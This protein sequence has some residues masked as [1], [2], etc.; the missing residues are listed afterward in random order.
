[1]IMMLVLFAFRT[2]LRSVIKPE[3]KCRTSKKKVSNESHVKSYE[4]SSFE[5]GLNGPTLP[6][7]GSDLRTLVWYSVLGDVVK[8]WLVSNCAVSRAV[9]NFGRGT[10]WAALKKQSTMVRMVILP[11]KGGKAIWDHG[12]PGVGTGL[13]SLVGGELEVLFCAQVGQTET[14]S[15]TSLAKAGHQNERCMNEIVG[16]LPGHL[17]LVSFPDPDKMVSITQIQ[18]RK[19]WM[20]MA[21]EEIG[22]LV[23]LI[24]ASV[25]K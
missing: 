10:N 9:G 16:F 24:Q 5:A 15:W 14:N 3:P 19:D 12:L 22:V 18:F 1:M 13:S 25:I 20:C 4:F 6:N 11:K 2:C 7:S 21:T 8:P 23:C 17:P